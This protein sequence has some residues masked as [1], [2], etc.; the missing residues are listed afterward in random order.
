M[1]KSSA[2]DPELRRAC[3]AAASSAR[4]EEV[5]SGLLHP[6]RKG[7]CIFEKLDKLAKPRVPTLTGQ[8]YCSSPAS[9]SICFVALHA[10]LARIW[11]GRILGEG[12]C[13]QMDGDEREVVM[14]V[15]LTQIIFQVI[16]AGRLGEFVDDELVPSSDLELQS[17]NIYYELLLYLIEIYFRAISIALRL[18]STLDSGICEDQWSGLCSNYVCFH[19]CEFMAVCTSA[20]CGLPS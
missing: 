6:C 20:K 1:T 19:G 17:S 4:R 7:C 15:G 18:H 2:D 16:K 11:D 9:A 3:A 10:T 14:A 5:A 8:F 12:G 13:Y